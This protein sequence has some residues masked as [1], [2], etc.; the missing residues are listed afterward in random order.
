MQNSVMTNFLHYHGFDNFHIICYCMI[1]TSFTIGTPQ[2][3]NQFQL[4]N[5]QL[6][7]VIKILSS[8]ISIFFIDYRLNFH[9]KSNKE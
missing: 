7:I 3:Y 1:D 9:L 5:Y 8:Q 2:T 6:N 4:I